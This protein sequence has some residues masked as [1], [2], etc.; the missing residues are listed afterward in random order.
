MKL[1]VRPVVIVVIAAT[2]LT[3][4][5]SYKSMTKRSPVTHETLAKLETGKKYVFELAIGEIQTIYITDLDTEMIKGQVIQEGKRIRNRNSSSV[6]TVTGQSEYQEVYIRE[7]KTAYADSREN[8]LKNVVRIYERK[9]D[10]VKTTALIVVPA[11][12]LF[13]LWALSHLPF[14]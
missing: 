8:I 4:C 10:P 6:N 14:Q 13:G 7:I 5:Y 2:V 1:H 11:G 12:L 3:S 9:A